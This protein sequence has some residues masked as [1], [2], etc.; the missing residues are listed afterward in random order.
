MITPELAWNI[1][2]R[3]LHL[4]AEKE[5]SNPRLKEIAERMK[6]IKEEMDN[7]IKEVEEMAG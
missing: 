7:L 3:G 6:V 5:Y 2:E 1:L 4:P